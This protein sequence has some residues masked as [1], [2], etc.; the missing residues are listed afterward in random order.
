MLL[1]KFVYQENDHQNAVKI[2]SVYNCTNKSPEVKSKRLEMTENSLPFDETFKAPWKRIICSEVM[3]QYPDGMH[4]LKK[5]HRGKRGKTLKDI[6]SLSLR[7]NM[8]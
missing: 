3:L 6:Y 7:I 1:C 4:T 8:T 5:P 2:I